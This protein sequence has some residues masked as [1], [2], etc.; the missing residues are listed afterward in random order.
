M[1]QPGSGQSCPDSSRRTADIKKA[2]QL[3]LRTVHSEQPIGLGVSTWEPLLCESGTMSARTAA[4]ADDFWLRLEV[5]APVV[6]LF[7]QRANHVRRGR[8]EDPSRNGSLAVWH[9]V[10]QV[11]AGGSGRLRQHPGCRRVTASTVTQDACTHGL[12]NGPDAREGGAEVVS[13]SAHD[14]Q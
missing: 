5:P 4:C 11:D 6:L 8:L 14:A 12:D 3:I 9:P 1:S 2:A 10:E 7:G 13:R